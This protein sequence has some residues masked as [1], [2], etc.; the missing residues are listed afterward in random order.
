[1]CPDLRLGHDH[2]REGSGVEHVLTGPRQGRHCFLIHGETV[3]HG[4]PL[5]V[6]RDDDPKIILADDLQSRA[7]PML[8]GRLET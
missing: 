4:S 2:D 6:V 3:L 5:G 7:R 1:M 8:P